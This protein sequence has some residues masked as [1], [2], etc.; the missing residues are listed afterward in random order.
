MSKRRVVVTGLGIVSPVGNDVAA[1]WASILAGRSG[2]D[3]IRRFDTANFPTHFGGEIRE[4][5]LEPYMS[6]KDARRM[7]AFM[8]YGVIAGMQAMRDSGLAVTEAN[9]D[10]IGVLMGSGM[11]GLE[12]IEQTYDKY[13]ETHSPKK[14]SPFFIPAS[15]INLVSGH[16]SIAFNITGPNLA[17]ATACTTSTHA[18][19][20]AMR[21]IQYGEADAM[22]AGGAE[23]STCVT[24]MSGFAQAKAL[25][26]RNDDPQ[27]ASRPW[28]KD[29]DGFVMGDGAGAMMLEEYEHA[30]ARGANIYAEIVGFGMSGDAFHVTAPPENGEGAR[31]AMAKALVDAQ[32]NP[33]R[34]QYVNAHATSTGLGDRAETTAIRRAFGPAA[35]KL[36]VS[37]TKSMTGH[38]L[39]AAGAVEA[40]FCV[41]ALRDQ[42]APP[43]INLHTP[44]EGCDLDYVPNSARPMSIEYTLSNSFG[45]GGTNGSL[46]FRR[47]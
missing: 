19:G 42:V 1:A 22:L 17:V 36:A 38:L 3:V 14:V 33:D 8:Q 11:G 46:I 43:T 6:A 29:R 15:I 27:G 32:L 2:I 7:D 10:R 9:S 44:G 21:L 40:I 5:N 24:G 18:V 26:Q 39:G 37:S 30:K 34:V 35:D 13:L 28:D 45:F 25:S 23:M 47:A 20:L 16:L 31:K 4:L 12:S 41:L